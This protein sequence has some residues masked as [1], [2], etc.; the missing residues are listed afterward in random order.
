MKKHLLLI[1]TIF[2][3]LLLTVPMPIDT[4][5]V[6]EVSFADKVAHFFMF[7]IFS[8]LVIY[9]YREK[10]ENKGIYLVSAVS[11]LLYSVLGEL[12][13][14]FLPNRTVSI[15]DIYAG[16]VGI[17]FFVVYDYVRIKKV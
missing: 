3:L 14:S 4:S 10:F 6:I 12:I 8:Y 1:W 15:A 2:V 7:G 9:T 11:G 5:E 17:L 16:A 13:Q